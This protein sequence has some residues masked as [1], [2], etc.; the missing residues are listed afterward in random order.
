MYPLSHFPRYEVKKKT[1]I[2][3]GLGVLGG[4]GVGVPIKGQLHRDLC[5]EGIVLHI[6]CCDGYMYLHM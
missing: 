6:D 1:N 2:F 4:K 3:Q 5:G